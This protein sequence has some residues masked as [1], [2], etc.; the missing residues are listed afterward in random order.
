MTLNQEI[1]SP[2]A[3][4]SI[5]TLESI[6]DCEYL[7]NIYKNKFDLDIRTIIGEIDE[8]GIYRC[9]ETNYRFY[10]PLNLMG[11]DHFYG[12]F[13]KYDWYYLPWKW[14][15][16]ECVKHVNDGD[17]ILEV[18]AAKGD[19]LL[20][21]QKL[22]NVEC[23]G[24]ELNSDAIARGKEIGVD[25]LNESV[26]K[27]AEKNYQKYDLVCSFQVLEH[28]SNVGEVIESMIA[29]IKPGGKL[30][31]SVPNNDSF[32]KDN[33]LPSRVLNMPPHHMGLWNSNSLKNLEK[34]FP[35]SHLNNII[36]PLE[37]IH[38]DTYQYT[39][40]YKLLF[41]SNVLIKIYWKIRIYKL[42]KFFLAIFSNK[43]RGQSVVSIFLKN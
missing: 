19:F 29:C 26:E 31:I 34:I 21:L 5:A 24:L 28:I 1:R 35:I 11:D 43:L 40:V 20:R 18:G 17:K 14:E 39:M 42:V 10:F 30:L 25:L 32:I 12:H 41:K 13:G 8:I 3:K 16:R 9:L 27:H 22:K 23:T 7:L 2:L 15:H 4:N 38:M 36:E 6:I 33:P 37:P